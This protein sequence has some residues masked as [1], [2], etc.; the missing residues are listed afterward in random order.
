MGVV[1][2]FGRDDDPCCRAVR[3]ELA[4]RRRDVLFVAE[5]RLF[6]GLRFAWTPRTRNDGRICYEGREISLADVDAVLSRAWGVPVAP[7]EFETADGRYVCAEWN[8]LLVAWL[9]ALPCPVFN[10][11]KPELWYKTQLNAA[12]LAA[13]LPDMPFRRPR[14]LVTTKSDEAISF[15][16]G[17]RGRVRYS[18]LTR[19]SPYRVRGGTDDAELVSLGSA[20]PLHLAERPDGD[21]VEAFVV[22]TEVVFDDPRDQGDAEGRAPVARLCLDVA[23]ALGLSFCKLSLIEA[24]NG[25]WYCLDLDRMPQLGAYSPHLQRKVARALADGL[26]AVRAKA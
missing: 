7:E 16:R 24:A 3:E 8:A 20:L 21:A 6:P 5:D 15:A 17:A 13:L 2:M 25:D 26:V 9:H 4:S 1:L 23:G 22:C 10:H 19:R 18:P 12:D 14:T 11:L